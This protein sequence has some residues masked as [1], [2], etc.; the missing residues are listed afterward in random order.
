MSAY[1]LRNSTRLNSNAERS[2]LK[3]LVTRTGENLSDL[4]QG[5]HSLGKYIED[6][7]VNDVA[8]DAVPSDTNPDP[9][10][11]PFYAAQYSPITKEHRDNINVLQ[12][13]MTSDGR[14]KYQASY[15]LAIGE[16]FLKFYERYIGKYIYSTIHLMT[17]LTPTLFCIFFITRLSKL[18]IR[19]NMLEQGFLAIHANFHR[20]WTKDIKN[21]EV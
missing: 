8:L 13:E 19:W 3:R 11:D 18:K 15:S 17:L 5:L 7:I 1:Y 21:I 6:E 2:S 20:N 12:I 4:L 9:G 10:L 14:K 16:A